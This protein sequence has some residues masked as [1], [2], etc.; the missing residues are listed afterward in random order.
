MEYVMGI[1]AGTS[2]VKATIFSL[3]GREVARAARIV[4][5]TNPES[6]MAEEDL[7][8]VWMAALVPSPSH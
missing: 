4:P 3:E 7:Q 2:V 6:Y 1:D 8:D 5:I